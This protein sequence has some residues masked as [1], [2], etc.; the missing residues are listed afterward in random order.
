[1]AAELDD[2][3][4]QLNESMRRMEV[5]AAT[6]IGQA[7][8]LVGIVGQAELNGQRG[9]IESYDA[10]KCRF[11]VRLASGKGIL[12]RSRNLQ[13]L[14]SPDIHN[15]PPEADQVELIIGGMR[16]VAEREVLERFPH[17]YFTTLLS[18]F[19]MMPAAQGSDG[20]LSIQRPG[21]LFGHILTFLRNWPFGG[22]LVSPNLTA[23]ER[24]ELAMEADFYLLEPLTWLLC[25]APPDWYKLSAKDVLNR[26]QVPRAEN[27]LESHT[28]STCE[29]TV[30]CA[31][32]R[33]FFAGSSASS[34]TCPRSSTC[35]PVSW[36]STLLV[37]AN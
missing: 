30:P 15:S 35:M 21:H 7:A 14:E 4:S 28:P 6:M 33:T 25:N 29:C 24:N 34:E 37:M 32:R 26:Q 1:M 10:D 36:R 19:E 27:T 9:M 18:Q 5:Q 31:R 23:T 3:I 16:Y 22:E 11:G 8:T 12:V 13:A 20:A 2:C 17:S